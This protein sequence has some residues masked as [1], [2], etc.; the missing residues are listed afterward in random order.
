MQW[1]QSGKRL[2]LDASSRA[3]LAQLAKMSFRELLAS[4]ILES[5]DA[6]RENQELKAEM[7]ALT[8]HVAIP[9]TK[10]IKFSVLIVDIMRHQAVQDMP[11]RSQAPTA[12]IECI[13][14]YYRRVKSKFYKALESTVVGP[15]YGPDIIT[16]SKAIVE[17]SKVKNF[18]QFA[19]TSPLF[20]YRAGDEVLNSE[21]AAVGLMETWSTEC[22]QCR[23]HILLPGLRRHVGKH[24]MAAMLRQKENLDKRGTP[25]DPQGYPCGFCGQSGICN[26]DLVYNKNSKY[27]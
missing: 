6:R 11:P 8:K 2:K 14:G 5:L 7:R 18:K 20:P 16:A 25:V 13:R 1:V 22:L 27:G 17:A 19:F 15:S 21:D 23:Q 4:S 12:L 24:I 10:E 3:T 9:L 26:I